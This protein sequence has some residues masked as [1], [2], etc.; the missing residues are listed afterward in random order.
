[1]KPIEITPENANKAFNA[2][3]EKGKA[4]LT[5]LLGEETFKAKSKARIETFEEALEQ[6]NIDKTEFENS[7]KGL[8]T[9]EV[10]YRKIKLIAKALNQGWTPDW[11]NDNEYKYYPYFNM[12]SGVGFSHSGYDYRGTCTDVGSRLCYK[13]SDLATYAGKQFESIYKDFLTL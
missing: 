10:A 12:Q 1:M 6:F 9:D 7:C 13:S 4:L 3:D 11:D 2:A 8:T 5:A